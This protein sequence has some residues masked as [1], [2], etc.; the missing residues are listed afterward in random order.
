[1]KLQTTKKGYI[2]V[3]LCL[4][5]E[6]KIY[7]VHRLVAETFIPNVENLPEVNHKD[8]D[9]SN[10]NVNNLEWCSHEYNIHYGTGMERMKIA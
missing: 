7:H 8:E 9:K 6:Q 4:N 1:M 5:G 3:K 2:Y 10:N